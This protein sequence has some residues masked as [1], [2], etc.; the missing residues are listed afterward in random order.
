MSL[1]GKPSISTSSLTQGLFTHVQSNNNQSS[2][3]GKK[4]NL[5]CD[6]S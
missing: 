5:G 6:N 3:F 1:F 2:L 4:D